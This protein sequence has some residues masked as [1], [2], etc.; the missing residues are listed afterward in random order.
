[1][2]PTVIYIKSTGENVVL[3]H[4]WFAVIVYC[5]RYSFEYRQ[6]VSV[7][8]LPCCL[9]YCNEGVEV[10]AEDFLVLVSDR[11][12]W[13]VPLAVGSSVSLIVVDIDVVFLVGFPVGV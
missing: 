3:F 11:Y 2:Q 4:R 10:S 13:G 12:Q 9:E 1:M 7:L 6:G 5:S 8:A